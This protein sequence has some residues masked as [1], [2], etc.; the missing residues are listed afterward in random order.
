MERTVT[1]AENETEREMSATNFTVTTERRSQPDAE[2]GVVTFQFEWSSFAAV[3]GSRLRAGEAIERLFLD[4][5]VNLQFSWPAQYRVESVDPAPALE[6]DQRVVW[7]GQLDFDAGQPSVVLT[8]AGQLGGDGTTGD[9]GEDGTDGQTSADSTGD[10][11]V[12]SPLVGLT[13]V[14]V[15]VLAGIAAV[16]LRTRRK[17]DQTGATPSNTESE[18]SAETGTDESAPPA[19]LLSNEERVLRLLEENGGR[20][21]QQAVAE[22]LDWTAAKT[23]QVVSDLRE[24]D[25]VESFR[26]GRENVLTLPD[27][28]LETS[29]GGDDE[30][31]SQV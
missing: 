28:D 9:G 18:K 26:L 16:A 19:E 5:G 14:A 2:F 31:D 27:V 24:A 7:R 23:S 30:A 22:E 4:E 25:S 13:I 17:E 8:G 11:G 1:T 21:K 15:A 29:T 12:L 10:G 20:V 6:E 3:D